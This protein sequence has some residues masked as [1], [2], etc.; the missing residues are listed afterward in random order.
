MMNE[1]EKETFILLVW[2]QGGSPFIQGLYFNT[3]N[4][5]EVAAAFMRAEESPFLFFC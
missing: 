5:G 1:M 3:R 4:T 2:E